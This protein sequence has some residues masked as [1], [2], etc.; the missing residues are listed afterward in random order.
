MKHEVSPFV[1][2]IL[3]DYLSHTHRSI[4]NVEEK[5]QKNMSVDLYQIAERLGFFFSDANLCRQR[6][7]SNLN[8]YTMLSLAKNV[9]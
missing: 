5:T 6:W 8:W 9:L 7:S 1:L 3:R 2:N 4:Y